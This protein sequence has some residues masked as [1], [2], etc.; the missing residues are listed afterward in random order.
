M[1]KIYEDR[2]EKKKNFAE[3]V[4]VKHFRQKRFEINEC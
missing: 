1:K 2:E 4:D 3:N